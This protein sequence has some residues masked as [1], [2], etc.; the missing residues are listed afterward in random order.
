MIWIWA[1]F[2]VIIGIIVIMIACYIIINH[3]LSKKEKAEKINQLNTQIEENK[4]LNQELNNLKEKYDRDIAEE[5]E[6]SKKELIS[7]REI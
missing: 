1:Y 2:G 7:E 3:I 5:K 4:K 6:R